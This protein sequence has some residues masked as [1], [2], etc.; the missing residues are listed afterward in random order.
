METFSLSI[1]VNL[2]MSY[3]DD[4]DDALETKQGSF[5]DSCSLLLFLIHALGSLEQN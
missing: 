5:T 4:G 2:G 1:L 3:D